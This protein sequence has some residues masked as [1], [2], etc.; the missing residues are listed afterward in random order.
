MKLC[1]GHNDSKREFLGDPVFICNS[2]LLK[3]VIYVGIKIGLINAKGET[4]L[5]P[6]YQ[7]LKPF[8]N[9]YARAKL[10]DKW[11]I[12][13]TKGKLVIAAEYEDLGTYNNGNTWAKNGDILFININI[14]SKKLK[15]VFHLICVIC[16][17]VGII[18][19]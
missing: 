13:D 9:G 5:K 15:M 3:L 8:E 17:L 10:N 12:I 2:V 19:Y 1:I 6:T 14:F 18:L 4:V 11:G 7:V 16:M